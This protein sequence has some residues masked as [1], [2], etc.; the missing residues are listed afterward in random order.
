MC[1]AHALPTLYYKTFPLQSR[2]RRS[3]FET[4]AAAYHTK[5]ALLQPSRAKL[6]PRQLKVF[7]RNWTRE[8][9]RVQA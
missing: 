5:K 6:I 2:R 1:P 3:A 8:V 7:N 4:S 9:L